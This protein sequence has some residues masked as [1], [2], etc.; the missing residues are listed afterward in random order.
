MVDLKKIITN[1]GDSLSDL[2]F[3]Q[4]ILLVFLR[5]F[6]CIFCQQAL[7]DLSSYKKDIESIPLHLIF[8]HMGQPEIAEE[9]F[10]KYNL[11]G[12]AH[13]S[14]PQCKVYNEFGLTKGN[15]SQLFG[16]QT[17]VKGFQAKKEGLKL[18]TKL[19]GDSLQMPGIFII[20]EGNV[21]ERY[22]HKVASDRPD[23][24]ALINCCSI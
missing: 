24:K 2:S 6:G 5:H 9:F 4:P 14:D 19:I 1:N 22:I 13:I 8:V 21:K 18:S 16:L 10:G 11:S 15:V 3:D 20:K 7:Q 23:Y 12:V 17:W